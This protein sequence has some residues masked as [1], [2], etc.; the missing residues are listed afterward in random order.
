MHPPDPLFEE[1]G[2]YCIAAVCQS[3]GRSVHEQFPFIFFA[4]DTRIEIKLVYMF[5]IMMSM[6]SSILGLIKQFLTELCFMNSEKF[7]IFA[8]SVIFFGEFLLFEMQLSSI[9]I[10]YRYI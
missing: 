3:V 10:Y 7:Q 2:T 4:E 8:V 1:R 5:I 6:T 9:H